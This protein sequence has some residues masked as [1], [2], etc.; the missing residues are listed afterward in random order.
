MRVFAIRPAAFVRVELVTAQKVTR[1]RT[2][3]AIRGCGPPQQIGLQLL[4]GL[5]GEVLPA[6]L[7]L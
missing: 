6:F 7:V 5:G 2:L 4:R 3:V 1:S